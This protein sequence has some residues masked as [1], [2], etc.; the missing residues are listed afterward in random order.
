MFAKQASTRFMLVAVFSTAA[1]W[2]VGG[3]AP[4][5]SGASPVEPGAAPRPVAVR[6]VAVRTGDL[7]S[8]AVYVG[9]ARPRVRATVVARV[10]GTLSELVAD[11]GDAVTAG[12]H[13]ARV[14]TPDAAARVERAKA[15]SR[16]ARSERDYLCD[17][18]TKDQALREAG[19]IPGAAADLGGKQCDTARAGVR[20]AEAQVNELVA[21]ASKSD[22]EAPLTGR[23]LERLAE[24]GEHVLPGRPLLVLGGDELEVVLPLTEG[25]RA[26]GVG[27]GTPAWV[28]VRGGA[29]VQTTVV[30]LGPQARGPGRTVEATVALPAALRDSSYPGQ[31]LD[32]G[33]VLAEVRGATSVP[34]D[35]LGASQ[36]GP[37]VFLVEGDRLV[38]RPVRV[39]L[40]SQ[41][42][43]A[44]A[45]ALAPEARVVVGS[46][47]GLA[48]DLPVYP[49]AADGGAP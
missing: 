4:A 2:L 7:R 44:I 12:Q 45:P 46:L 15:E 6:T 14:L 29:T 21:L 48:H 24:P 38:R 35:A 22:E 8:E 13:L 42:W 1:A 17:R 47:R 30:A 26:R 41:G 28:R 37:V 10:A 16:R 34:S 36:D 33:L 18:F 32:V 39:V 3:C 5:A 25:D 40:S 11:E 19:A 20:A 31:S 43:A 49:V 23:V 27:V 9:T